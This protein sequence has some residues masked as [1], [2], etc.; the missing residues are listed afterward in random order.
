MLANSGGSTRNQAVLLRKINDDPFI[1]KKMN[2]ELLKI[3]VRHTTFS[4]LK[5]LQVQNTFRTSVDKG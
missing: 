2:Q 4:M 5:L 3:R 1:M